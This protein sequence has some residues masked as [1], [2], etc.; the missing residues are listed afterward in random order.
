VIAAGGLPASALISTVVV[1]DNVNGSAGNPSLQL[2]TV[3]VDLG[4]GLVSANAAPPSGTTVF[5]EIT[6]SNTTA[7]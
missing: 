4:T 5:V 1:A 7:Y 3:T 2:Q 6:L